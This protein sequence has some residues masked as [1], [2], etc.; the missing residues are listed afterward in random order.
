[1]EFGRR[2]FREA[3]LRAYIIREHRAGRA[4]ADI[5]GDPYVVRCGNESFRWSVLQ[6]PRT[7]EALRRNDVEA[8]RRLSAGLGH[9]R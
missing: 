1:M 9:E 2:P 4:L 5:L 8:F 6:D 7:V 3:R